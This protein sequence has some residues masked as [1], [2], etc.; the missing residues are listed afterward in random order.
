MFNQTFRNI[1]SFFAPGKKS[2]FSENSSDPVKQP[3]KQPEETNIRLLYHRDVNNSN[4]QIPGAAE[5][6]AQH[7][8]WIN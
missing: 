2:V 1:C 4:A 8:W 6:Q 7:D 5:V 3:G